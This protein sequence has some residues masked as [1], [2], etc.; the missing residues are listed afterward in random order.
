M[1]TPQIGLPA[2][3]HFITISINA[4]EEG[5]LHPRYGRDSNSH[6]LQTISNPSGLLVG[7][8]PGF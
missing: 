3:A 7:E 6:M 8:F 1:E 5:V 4:L 2:A